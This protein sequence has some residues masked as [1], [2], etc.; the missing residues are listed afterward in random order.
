MDF[1][2]LPFTMSVLNRK[3]EAEKV[4]FLQFFNTFVTGDGE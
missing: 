4:G 3:T 1:S 2:S